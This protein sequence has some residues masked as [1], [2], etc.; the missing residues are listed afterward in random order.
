M[1]PSTPGI[2][3]GPS[4]SP[5]MHFSALKSELNVDDRIALTGSNSTPVK[6]M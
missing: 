5:S 3:S 1:K 2:A 4:V 6:E